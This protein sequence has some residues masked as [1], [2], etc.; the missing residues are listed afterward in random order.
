MACSAFLKL[1]IS[2]QLFGWLTLILYLTRVMSK[3]DSLGIAMLHH[4]QWVQSLQLFVQGFFGTFLCV[5]EASDAFFWFQILKGFTWSERRLGW[6]LPQSR[7]TDPTTLECL[8]DFLDGVVPRPVLIP[9]IDLV[10]SKSDREVVSGSEPRINEIKNQLVIVLVPNEQLPIVIQRI[11]DHS[12]DEND[13]TLD[14][15][16]AFLDLSP[17]KFDGL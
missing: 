12:D 4:N 15:E 10:S 11:E 13:A 3:S 6:I 16:L 9:V 17:I 2:R 5:F 14:H 8:S 7:T 1:Y